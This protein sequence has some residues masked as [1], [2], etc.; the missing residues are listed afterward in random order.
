M[1]PIHFSIHRIV[2]QLVTTLVTYVIGFTYQISLG[3]VSGNLFNSVKLF[4]DY[5]WIVPLFMV[6]ILGFFHIVNR[7]SQM[8]KIK[9]RILWIAI[10]A[11]VISEF[12]WTYAY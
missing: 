2:V 7:F 1:K 3:Y 12:I 10:I 4:Q 6:S 11:G 9:R 5:F 8:Y